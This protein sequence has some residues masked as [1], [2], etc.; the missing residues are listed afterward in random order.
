MRKHQRPRLDR[1]AIDVQLKSTWVRRVGYRYDVILDGEVVVRRS[2]DPEYDAARV[3]Q[4]RCLKGTFRTID[5][6]TGRPRM[7]LDIEKAAGLR[8][9]ERDR[10]GLSIEPYLPMSDDD[11]SRLRPP[12]L[13]HEWPSSPGM[14]EDTDY[15]L[16]AAG[17]GT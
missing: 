9:V 5:F 16:P 17:G 3:L 12:G 15:P 8:T 14:A 6:V 2:S 13:L 1:N 11:R 7:I 10:G 4:S